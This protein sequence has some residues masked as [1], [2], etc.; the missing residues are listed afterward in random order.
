MSNF[1]GSEKRQFV[2]V[3]VDI[4]V[5][6]RFIGPSGVA[7]TPDATYSGKTGNVGAGGL[8][9]VAQLPEAELIADL[10]MGKV[11]VALEL[12]LPEHDSISALSRVAWLETVDEQ[13][14]TCS[15]GLTF[16]EITASAQD[17]L[18]R[19]VINSVSF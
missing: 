1:P 17:A 9:L 7:P 10:L 8:L 12:F 13:N 18:F 14:N 11:A 2:R 16:K 6:Y 5:K 4:E 19:F 15:I 3:P